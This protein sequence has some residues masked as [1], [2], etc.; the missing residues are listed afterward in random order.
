M[1]FEKDGST[2][3]FNLKRDMS[4]HEEKTDTDEPVSDE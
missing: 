2:L 1:D 4:K 3:S